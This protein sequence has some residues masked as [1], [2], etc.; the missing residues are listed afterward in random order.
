MLQKLDQ[1]LNP[2]IF[3]SIQFS[4]FICPLTHAVVQ[5]RLFSHSFFLDIFSNILYGSSSFLQVSVR[6]AQSS[7]PVQPGIQDIHVAYL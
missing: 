5:F 7:S 6:A 1:T 4:F 2:L 3:F